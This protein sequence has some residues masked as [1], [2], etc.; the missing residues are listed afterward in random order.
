MTV[1]STVPHPATSQSPQKTVDIDRQPMEPDEAMSDDSKVKVLLIDDQVMVAESISRLL[2]ANA[3]DIE[4]YYC[5]DVQQA[6]PIAIEVQPTVI[7]QDLI[8]PDTDGLMLVT[9]F[10]ANEVTQA[11]PVIVLSTKNDSM[12]KAEAFATG[13][14]DYLVKLP[15][16]IEFVARVRYH[17]AAYTNL[18]KSQAAEQTLAYNRELEKRVAER[19]AELESALES[20]KQ[21]QAQLIQDEKMASLGQLIAGVAH[22]INNPINFIAGNLKHS[23]MYA[24]DLLYLISLYQREY[25]QPTDIIQEELDDLNLDFL[26]EDFTKLMSSLSIGTDRIRNIVL[27]L[28]NFSRL[29]EAEMHAVDIHDGIDSTLMILSSKLKSITVIKD[30]GECPQVECFPSQLNQVFMNILANAADALMETTKEI[31]REEPKA[32]SSHNSQ[33]LEISIK[34]E[35]VQDE[36][37]Q[38]SIADNGPGIPEETL[39]KIFEAF[40]TTK[41]VGLGT[42]LGLSISYQIV[43]QRHRGLLECFSTLGEGTQFVIKIPTVHAAYEKA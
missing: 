34:T 18:L 19:T 27:S 37:V 23:Q 6:I 20:L 24:N 28:R 8:M 7:L 3:P 33:S 29:D 39:S 13:A 11:I 12:S 10:R 16:P 38:I 21:T 26:S 30:Y 4:F 22:E 9:F 40:F 36:F 43:T 15:D 42:G 17:S 35:L 25:P 41:P 2:T 1:F 31:S 32:S 5:S 14:N